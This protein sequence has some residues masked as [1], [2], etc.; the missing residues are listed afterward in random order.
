MESSGHGVAWLLPVAGSAGARRGAPGGRG[1]IAPALPVRRRALR[2]VVEQV[3]RLLGV[4]GVHEPNG[5]R[6][7]AMLLL[8]ASYG[9]RGCEVR[10]LR[11]GRAVQVPGV[12]NKV[13]SLGYRFLP[14]SVIARGS[15][16][17][18]RAR[19]GMCLPPGTSTAAAN[20][21]PNDPTE[22]DPG[23]LT[24]SYFE[25][26]GCTWR[27]P[28]MDLACTWEAI[29]AWRSCWRTLRPAAQ[30]ALL[31]H[32]GLNRAARL[33][34]P[35]RRRRRRRGQDRRAGQQDAGRWLTGA[36]ASYRD[37]RANMERTRRHKGLDH[38]G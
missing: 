13:S 28:S 30:P 4:A 5:R 10:A 3:R 16:W 8:I 15:G 33:N 25:R 31:P 17:S 36:T 29:P 1:A 19:R 21:M 2:L 27:G 7:Y 6:N 18:V 20:R 9:L 35:G 32:P 22:E 37:I 14:R 26:A 12:L 34:P 23:R 11:R 24:E 38:D